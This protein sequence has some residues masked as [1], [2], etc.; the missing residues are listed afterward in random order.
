MVVYVFILNF[1]IYIWFV[2]MAWFWH[3]CEWPA[4]I[5]DVQKSPFLLVPTLFRNVIFICLCPLMAPFWFWRW[6]FLGWI[7][8]STFWTDLLLVSLFLFWQG[9]CLFSLCREPQ[10]YSTLGTSICTSVGPEP[11]GLLWG[12]PSPK[13]SRGGQPVHISSLGA[14]THLCPCCSYGQKQLPLR[15]KPLQTQTARPLLILA[16]RT[17]SLLP[18]IYAGKP[19]AGLSTSLALSPTGFPCLLSLANR[20]LRW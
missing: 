19:C 6:T 8:I 20:E 12:M 13:T 3:C 9:F 17:R 4:I 15:Y 14:Q 18:P 5:H 1:C 10:G 7:L 11:A 2:W 16:S